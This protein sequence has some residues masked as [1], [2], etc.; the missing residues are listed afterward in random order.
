M[1][2]VFATHSHNRKGLARCVSLEKYRIQQCNG[3]TNRVGG[4]RR[5]YTMIASETL[6]VLTLGVSTWKKGNVGKRNNN[7]T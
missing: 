4:E 5:T 3:G 6:F 2:R 1:I 7:I